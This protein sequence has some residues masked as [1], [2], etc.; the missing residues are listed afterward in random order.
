MAE[1]RFHADLYHRLAVIVLVLPPLRDR[2]SDIVL[3]AQ[4][5]LQSTPRPIG[6]RPNG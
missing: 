3:L 2:G 6:S 4:Q 1:G 5:F